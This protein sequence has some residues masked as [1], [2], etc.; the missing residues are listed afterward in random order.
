MAKITS[1]IAREILD[2]RGNPTVETAVY[3]DG[4]YA[5]ASVPSGA[6]TGKFEAVELR[7]NDNMRF[8]GMGVR[9]AVSNVNSILGPELKGMEVTDQVAIDRKMINLDG[10]PNKAKLGS[11]SILSVSLAVAKAAS[12]AQKIPLYQWFN[13]LFEQAG[14]KATI[15]VPTPICNV[16]N[17]GKHG[18]GNLD[19][20][21]FQII[22]ASTKQFPEGLRLCTEIYH[23]VREVLKYRNALHGVGDEGGFAPNLYTNIDAVE[24]IADAIEQ[25]GYKLQQDVFF[26]L[27]I[28][29][30]YFYKNGKY[31]IKDA[32]EAYT[33]DQFIE[34]IQKLHQR[35][36]LF[37]L[38]D[39]LYEEAWDDWSKLT[40]ILG[41][42][43]HII[44]DDLLVT[45]PERLK[46]AIE[47]KAAN[48]II[49]KPNQIGTVF[50]TLST[51]KLAKENNFKVIVSHR[52]GET[53]DFLIADM[54]CGIGADF[55]KF[56]A[57]ARG[58]RVVKYNRLLTI[59]YESQGLLL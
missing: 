57:P 23:K 55:A 58:E 4:G 42:E 1:I 26:G 10:T 19:F 16:I 2:S 40:R 28:A 6:S 18:T 21:E 33:A 38:E 50:E 11:N 14:Y 29:P 20:Q 43:I 31:Q 25:A 52:S 24:V 13:K 47:T 48:A 39:A 17:G 37:C 59:A 5:S 56:G 54:A 7:D 51:V 36:Q 35:Y 49:I 53:T 15:S 9:K 27:D 46:K 12:F 34:Y 22:P 3:Y 32:Q 41:H 30:A 45:N 8:N 44:G